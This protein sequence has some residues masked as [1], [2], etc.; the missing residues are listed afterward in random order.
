MDRAARSSFL[1]TLQ[2]ADGALPI[3]RFAHSY[4]LESWLEANPQASRVDLRELVQSALRRSVATLDGAGVALSH[5]A[6]ARGDLDA[7]LGIDAALTARK[8][9]GPARRASTLCG[10]QLASL[11]RQLEIGGSVAAIADEVAAGR[12]PG[13]L[14]VLEGAIG[15]ELG[16]PRE[17]AVLIAVRGSAA[18]M[19]SAAVRLGRL[20]A[21]AG[22]VLLFE[23][24]GELE[25]CAAVALEVRVE[26]LRS[27]VPELDIHAAR[28]DARE[29][30]FFLT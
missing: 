8:L 17:Q 2:F 24:A 4:G 11:A 1:R 27:T 15:A 26:S 6:A 3:G 12:S 21:G 29:T 22:Q 16:T 28:Q 9:S 25:R 5:D 10:G 30:R 20:G 13:N 19:V 7:S 18:A 23:L 14:A